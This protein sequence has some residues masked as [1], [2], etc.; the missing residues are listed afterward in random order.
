MA[1]INLWL[2]KIFGR[3]NCFLFFPTIKAMMMSVNR[4]LYLIPF[5]IALLA[6]FSAANEFRFEH[7]TVEQG[8]SNSTVYSIIQDKTGFLWFG[9]PNGLNKYD[10]YHVTVF[11]N[12]PGDSTSIASNNAGNLYLA[13]N[14]KIWIGSWGGGV[15]EFDPETNKAVHYAYDP[16]NPNSL[17]DNRVQSIY[18]DKQGIM[19]FG[20]FSGGLNRFDPKSHRFT[21]YQLDPAN[22]KSISNNRIWAITG[23]G[24][25]N[26]W[27]ATSNGLNLFDPATGTAL[28]YYH[29]PDDQNSLNHNTVRAL[30]K[31]KDSI[32]WIGTSVG[33]CRLD[34][35]TQKFKRFLYNGGSNFQFNN[36]TITSIML[37]SHGR[38]WVGAGKGIYILDPNSGKLQHIVPV[39]DNPSALSD[40]EIRTI[41]QD[42]SGV[43][44][45]G[46][47]NKG[48]EKYNPNRKKFYNLYSLKPKKYRIKHTELNALQGGVFHGQR[49]LYFSNIY[50]F[51]D[52]IPERNH[53]K[54][55]SFKRIDPSYHHGNFIRAIEFDPTNKNFLWLATQ[56]RIY[57]YNIKTE[58]FTVINFPELSLNGTRFS[59]FTSVLPLNNKLW[60][61]NYQGGLVRFDKK[62]QV[63]DRYYIHTPNDSSSLSHNEVYFVQKAGPDG[64]WIG[65]GTALDYFSFETRKFTHHRFQGRS[66][67]HDRRFFCMYPQSKDIL[68]VGTEDGLIRY[69]PKIGAYRLF[70]MRDGL[71]DNKV[72]SI[73]LDDKGLLWIG[74]EHGLSRLNPENMVFD[75]FDISDGLVNSEYVPNSVFKD[76]EG[77]LYFGGKQGLD[78]FIP[79]SIHISHYNPA[80][81]LTGFQIFNKPVLPGKGSILVKNVN[82]LNKIRLSYEDYLFSFEFAALDYSN[83][84]KIK[85]AYMMDEID[86]NWI[87][88]NSDRRF[89]TYT[90]V[91]GGEYT[92]KV[93]AT[94]T[95]GQ[96]STDIKKLQII[97]TPAVWDT[98]WFRILIS[99]FIITVILLIFWVRL[100]SINSRNRELFEINTRLNEQMEKRERA[101]HEKSVLQ[102]QLLHSKKMEAIGLLAGGIAHDFNNLLTAIIGNVGL[103]QM[104]VSQNANL[105]KILNAAEK[106]CLRAK[107]LT[108]Q[109]LTFSKGGQPIREAASLPEVVNE[110]SQFVLTGANVK[111]EI[112]Y[113]ED[114]WLADIDKGQISQV[115]QNLVINAKQ[116]M[117]DGGKI[118]IRLRN[119]DKDECRKLGLKGERYIEMQVRDSGHGINPENLENI[120]TP[121]FSTKKEGSGLGLA[122]TYSVVKK[123]QGHIIVKSDVGI[124]TTFKVY[125]PANLKKQIK[126]ETTAPA[127]TR[128]TGRILLMDDE[129]AIRDVAKAMLENLG[130]RVTV[131]CDGQETLDLYKNALEA[132]ER[133]DV[134]I[135]DLTVPGG[136]GGRE[137]VEKL[138]QMDPRVK[139]IVSSGYSNDP[140]MADYKA[141]GFSAV[142]TKPYTLSEMSRSM[143]KILMVMQRK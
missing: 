34:L 41:F 91:P 56:G 95:D 84:S 105:D 110:S 44:W 127:V 77:T 115:V 133:F 82:S 93:K 29:N 2:I 65:T 20:T 28:H 17:S 128:G 19:W 26:L 31:A 42:R 114:L 129:D 86:R 92:F 60:L 38:L 100:R 113:P 101:E 76:S 72:S 64:L 53:L 8:L 139:A 52:Y 47:K 99:L 49:H 89:A 16:D 112:E 108:E 87:Y 131:A 7:L 5:I 136:M 37:G 33:F 90:H 140:I 130:Y 23:N 69:L 78:Y 117:N 35:K 116:A 96:W 46:T 3:L 118:F 70:T 137:T 21:R 30:L 122:V 58:S 1:S 125:L 132:K 98:L 107:N 15:D 13:Q 25:G 85:Y 9:T 123:H 79:D 4:I 134:V 18:E 135:L 63:I 40:D 55:F 119:A 94:N 83:P 73:V 111:C 138:F 75:N 43:F 11:K 80:V 54:F 66:R 12:I 48:V 14:G 39:P 27:L 45:L 74:T 106:A 61:G 88:T 57:R 97:I 126:A 62:R 6:G 32:L 24:D 22:P 50:G 124:G 51:F 59:T 102:K 109:L 104:S 142:M 103:A 81:V 68:W 10:G 120:F 141:Y 121:Y 36:N 143:Q 67:T 71:P